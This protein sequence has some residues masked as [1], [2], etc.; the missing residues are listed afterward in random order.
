[1]AVRGTAASITEK[2]KTRTAGATQQVIDGV[3]RVQTAP[4]AKAAAQKQVWLANLTAKA[5][6]WENNV[7]AVSLQ[8]W[9]AATVSGAQ[10]ISAGVQ[11]K[12]HKMESFLTEFL[13]HVERVQA[14]VHAMPRGNLEQNLTRMLENAR[15][16]AQFKRSGTR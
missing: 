16:L 11:A 8:S 7:K 2:W 6:K 15:G 13:P 3:Q 4:G 9:Q 14:K 1:M 10:R 12:A 5:D